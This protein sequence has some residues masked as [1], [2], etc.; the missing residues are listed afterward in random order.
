MDLIHLIGTS[1]IY[2]YENFENGIPSFKIISEINQDPTVNFIPRNYK[3]ISGDSMQDIGFL[4][5][6]P[7]IGWISDHFNTWLA[8]NSKTVALSI[9]Q[10]RFNY[11]INQIQTGFNMGESVGQG[12]SSA[13][14]GNLE[15]VVGAG[16]SLNS[17]MIS[18][19][20]NKGNHDFNI[21]QQ[22]AQIEKQQLLPD[23]ANLSSS[24]ATLLGY[25]LMD[26]N[27]FTR[28][29]I[30]AQFAKRIDKFFDMYG[31]LTNELKLPNLNNRPNWN[32]IKTIGANILGDIPQDDM[33][34]LKSLFDNRYN[35]M[36]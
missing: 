33:Q 7:T 13:I 28:Y 9:N 32:Y 25:D 26:K 8:Q 17:G 31:Y 20:A 35:F 10:E 21:K 14:T 29:N 24:N 34:I 23:N 19:F 1:K 16:S 4:N 2:R 5:G 6:Y 18:L 12:L 36:A 27:I 30:K 3:G 22:M 11:A 15:G